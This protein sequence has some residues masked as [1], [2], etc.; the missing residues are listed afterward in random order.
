MSEDEFE[1]RLGKMRATGSKRAK[2]YLS[3]VVAAAKRAGGSKRGSGAQFS[4]RRIGRGA[5]VGRVLGSRDRHAGFRQRR[6]VVKARLVKLAGKGMGGARA[7][8]SYIQRDGVTREG[9]PGRLYSAGE[10]GADG[11]VFL[12]RCEGDRHQFRFIVSVEDADQYDDLKPFVRR[13]M[14]QMEA[15]LG[16]KLDWVAVDH[17][18]TGHPHTHIVLRGRDDRGKDLIIARDYI[19]GGL[20]ERA[21]QLATLDLG[22]RTDLEIEERLRHDIGAERLTAID[23]RLLRGIDA[24]RVVAAADRDPFHQAL[25]A[26]RLQKLASL[27][28]AEHVGEGRWRLAHGLE[29]ALRR[30]GERGDIIRAMQRELTARK[31]ERADADRVIFDPS[32]EDAKSI[33]GRIVLRGLADEL[34]DRHY[35]IVDGIDGRTHYVEIGRGEALEPTPQDAIVR[36]AP[37]TGGV[38][39]VD[40]TIV[41][42][43]AANDGRYDLDAHLNHDPNA[44]EAFAE[45]HVRRL[46]A[47][48]RLMR[49]VEREPDGSWII[50]PDHLDKA[51]A[52]EARQLR[53][54]PVTVEVMSAVPLDRLSRAEAA[55]WLDRELIAEAPEPLRDA[56][57]GREVRTAQAARRQW[58]IAEELAEKKDGGTIY[59]RGMIA[60]LQR[61]EL[62]RVADQLSDEVGL[63]FVETKAGD[64]IEGKFSRAVEM[65]SGRHALI[66]RA[67]EFTLVPWRPVMERHVG[68]TVSGVMR[69]TGISWTIGR[70]RGGPAIE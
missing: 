23:R 40:R 38:R 20:R 24:D 59:R 50:A 32:A 46:E 54:R 10:D 35:L 36:I 69:G 66:E 21:V 53:E 64:R 15:D 51:A 7:H 62:L 45:T 49:N 58:L 14:A 11:K 18:N 9:E 8:L 6:S 33:T 60:A 57:F 34:N 68:K 43:A 48:R 30:M 27:G 13:L 55:T 3:Q 28:L 4:G 67:R 56:G 47:M 52:F 17:F 22:P 44:S 37:R 29:D 5:S 63:R 1:P 2:K 25:R 42:V 12:N 16:T 39:P 41:E 61:R 31:I 65:V 70:G 26:G 19:G